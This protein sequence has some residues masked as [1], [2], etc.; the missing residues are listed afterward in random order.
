VESKIGDRSIDMLSGGTLT[1][2][3]AGLRERPLPAAGGDQH[4]QP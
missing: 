1:A 3:H 4:D 2:G